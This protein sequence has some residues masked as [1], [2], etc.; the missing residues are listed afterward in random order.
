MSVTFRPSALPKLAA[1]VKYES[2]PF[3]GAAASRGTRMDEAFRHLLM[4]EMDA[5]DAL[6]EMDAD[7]VSWAVKTVETLALGSPVLADEDDLRIECLGMTGTA[8]A[9]CAAANISFDLKSGEIRNYREQM[10]AYALGFMDRFFEESWTCYLV[11]CDQRQVFRLDFTRESAERI[12]REVI[13]AALDDEAVATPCEYCDWCAKRFTCRTRLEGV[14]W[15]AGKDP[16]TIDWDAEL[17]DTGKLAAFLDMCRVI[18]SEGGLQDMAKE[19][20]KAFLQDGKEV[21]GYG[22]RNRAGSEFVNPTNVG[23]YIQELGFDAILRAYGN[24][25]ANKLR[26]I[27]AEKKP[28]TAFP[29]SIVETG[30]GSQFVAALPKKKAAKKKAQPTT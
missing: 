8:D 21:P 13:A 29:D 30:A 6:D 9:A 10:A 26:E 22:L 5:I 3:A 14:A 25:A 19:R 20:A 24:L 15:W 23:H 1:C 28:S 4:G 12:V 27:W 18:A 17:V 16:A 2:Q 11:Y 7:A